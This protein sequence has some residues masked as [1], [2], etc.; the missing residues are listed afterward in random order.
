MK[1]FEA[2]LI[3]TDKSTDFQ[4]MRLST[5]IVIIQWAF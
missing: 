3:F 2:G 4:V 5:I 1:L